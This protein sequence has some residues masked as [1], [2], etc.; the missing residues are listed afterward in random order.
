M[1]IS[2]IPLSRLQTD[3]PSLLTECCDSGRTIIVEL[4]NHRLVTIQSI[5]P[6]DP[7][8]SLVDE[9]LQSNPSFRA[10]V[11]KSKGSPR[12]TF[13]REAGETNER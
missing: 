5:E 10:L 11:E 8:D 4:P 6:D 2:T 12:R 13:S 3:A 9:L 1:D 7:D